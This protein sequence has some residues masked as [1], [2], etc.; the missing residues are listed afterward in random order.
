MC[1]ASHLG[2]I[3]TS[4]A[5]QSP[6]A[7]AFWEANSFEA[8]SQGFGMLTLASLEGR[9]CDA[10]RHAL[11]MALLYYCYRKNQGADS[12][13]GEAVVRAFGPLRPSRPNWDLAGPIGT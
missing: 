10:F 11:S 1:D 13:R 12:P 9:T 4:Y 3:L 8:A 5:R 6:G 2:S 7:S